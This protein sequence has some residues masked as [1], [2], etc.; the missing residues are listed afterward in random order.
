MEVSD[1]EKKKGHLCFCRLQI[2]L[3]DFKVCSLVKILVGT[4]NV[5]KSTT[6]KKEKRD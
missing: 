2:G 5:W 3:A 4:W 6:S 1:S